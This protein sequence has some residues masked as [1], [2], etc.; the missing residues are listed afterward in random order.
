MRKNAAGFTLVELIVVI[1]IILMTT[2]IGIATFTRSREKRLVFDEARQVSDLIRTAGRKSIAGEKPQ[3]CLLSTLERYEVRIVSGTVVESWAICQ[4]NDSMI[5]SLELTKSVITSPPGDT[6]IGFTTVS[7]GVSPETV[8]ICGSGY[9]FLITVTSAGS[10]S[11]PKD[12]G[13]C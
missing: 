11:T 6:E 4:G 10:V 13:S 12:D 1:G 8:T 7:A 2:G 3:S 9:K 5:S